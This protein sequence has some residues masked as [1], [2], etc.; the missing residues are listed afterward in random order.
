M[1]TGNVAS[2]PAQR[3]EAAQGTLLVRAVLV[4]AGIPVA[5]MW[6]LATDTFH[7]HSYYGG[8]AITAGVALLGVTLLVSFLL[9]D[10]VWAALAKR[11]K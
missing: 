5:A 6:L 4:L 8:P 7:I 3:D 9:F 11:L 2:I 10:Y 1:G